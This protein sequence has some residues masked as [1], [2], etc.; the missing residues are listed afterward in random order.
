MNG[1]RN[2][3][4]WPTILLGLGLVVGPKALAGQTSTGVDVTIHGS[5][6]LN[7]W[8]NSGRTNNA[9]VP[10]LAL[11]SDQ[12]PLGRRSLGAAI[13]Q[14]RIRIEARHESVL[15]GRLFGELDADFFGGQQPSSG[16]RTHPLLRLRRAYAELRW[17][18]WT[19]LV[20]QE[21][22]PLFGVNPVSVASTGFP[23]FA[24]AGNL[25][26]W[27]PQI[28]ATGWL[29]RDRPLRVGV[30]ATVLAPSAGEPV[31]PFLTQPD[32]AEASGRPGIE[33]RVV[34]RWRVGGREGEAGIGIHRGWLA[35]TGGATI[36]SRA[37]GASVVA[38]LTQAIEIRGEYFRGRALG[39]LGGGG[40]G[41]TTGVDGLAVRTSGGWAQ[42]VL[43]PTASVELGLGGGQ[44]NPRDGDLAGTQSRT[45]NRVWSFSTTWRPRPVILGIEVRRL[46]TSFGVARPVTA[47]ATHLNLSAGIEF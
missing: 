38:P 15:G 47:F 39:G 37:F 6:L 33:A 23:L 14:T 9:D 16:G 10:T 30:E 13:R 34:G 18:G 11:A 36:T 20:G 32:R 44:D 19:V 45:R 31:D 3:M 25:W 22:P 21:A 4:D 26:L 27:L 17:P 42:L 7:A 5:I 1:R 29:T 12:D 2:P 46:A 28:R 43:V 8:R 40:I 35:V 41:Q 24:A